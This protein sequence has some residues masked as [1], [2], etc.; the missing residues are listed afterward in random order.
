MKKLCLLKKHQ[1][2]YDFVHNL[3]EIHAFLNF[4]VFRMKD[5]SLQKM[6]SNLQ[7]CILDATLKIACH[8]FK[9]INHRSFLQKTSDF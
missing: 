4:P 2:K 9:K 1:E 6:T 5:L 3:N 7:P 8:F